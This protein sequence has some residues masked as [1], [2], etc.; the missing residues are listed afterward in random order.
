MSTNAR[1]LVITI[2]VVHG[3]FHLFGIAKAFGWAE[4][5]ELKEPISEW[6]G[7]VW[8]A[9]AALL[10][11]AAAA[12]MFR[13]GWWWVAAVAGAVQSQAVMVASWT[14][15]EVGTFVNVAIALAV[16]YDYIVVE[17]HAHTPHHELVSGPGSSPPALSS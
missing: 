12:L 5:E 6:L 14:D 7:V 3:A 16:V 1:R 17:R 8:L 13:I 15:T 11:A 2:L 10:F 4:V 9:A